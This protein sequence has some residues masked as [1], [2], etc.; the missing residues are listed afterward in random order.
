MVSLARSRAVWPSV[1]AV[2]TARLIVYLPARAAREPFRPLQLSELRPS[3]VLPTMR[4]TR[5]RPLRTS[6][7]AAPDV[8]AKKGDAAGPAQAHAVASKTW[9]TQIELATAIHDYIELF[10]NTP[11]AP[12]GPRDALPNRLRSQLPLTAVNAA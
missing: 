4:A 10:H 1:P 12:L 2:L 8:V 9:T 7:A 6:S 3:F 11:Q 5:V